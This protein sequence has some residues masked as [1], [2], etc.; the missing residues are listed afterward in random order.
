MNL[1]EE[2]PLCA[3]E[4]YAVLDEALEGLGGVWAQLVQVWG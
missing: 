2:R 1:L 3:V 4:L